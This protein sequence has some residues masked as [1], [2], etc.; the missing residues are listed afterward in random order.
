MKNTLAI[1][2][3]LVLIAFAGNEV[4]AQSGGMYELNPM[5]RPLNTVNKK[6]T[7]N[8]V[9]Y[10]KTYWKYWNSPLTW[11]PI[12][13]TE[14]FMLSNLAPSGIDTTFAYYLKTASTGKY[15]TAVAIQFGNGTIWATPHPSLLDSVSLLTSTPG[16]CAPCTG[17]SIL[18]GR[19]LYWLTKIKQHAGADRVRLIIRKDT[20]ITASGT[21]TFETGFNYNPVKSK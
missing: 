20:T 13:T 19:Q 15:R 17:D 5:S 8:G 2:L 1:L 10:E 18:V 21:A 6:T 14:A 7:E 16:A 12:D 9:T 4:I 11:N 3:S